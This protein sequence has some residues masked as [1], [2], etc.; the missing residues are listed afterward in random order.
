MTAL[1][2]QEDYDNNERRCQMYESQLHGVGGEPYLKY[3]M[4]DRGLSLETIKH[5]RLG[6]VVNPDPQDHKFQYRICIPHMN[7]R[8]VSVLRFRAAPGQ[9]GPKYL[10]PTGSRIS[11]YNVAQLSEPLDYVMVAEG[12]CLPGSA[13]VFTPQG[14]TRMDALDKGVPVAQYEASGKLTLV[15]PVAYV[16]KH[17]E[18]DLIEYANTRRYYSLTTPGH[19]MPGLTVGG[20][21][22]KFRAD[23]GAP[24]SRHI[25]RVGTLDGDGTGLSEDHLALM[26]AISADASVRSPKGGEPVGR[27]RKA[28]GKHYYVFGFTKV[29]KILRLT[30]ILDRLDIPYSSE[31]IK[32]GCQSICFSSTEEIEWMGRMLPHDLLAK[33]SLDEREFCLREMV[34]WDGN[35]VPNRNQHEYSSKHLA[36]AEWMQTLAHTAGRVSTIMA[37]SNAYGEWYKVSVLHGHRATS[38]Q[39]LRGHERR[40]PFSGVVYCVQ[41]PSGYFLVRQNGCVTITGNCDAMTLVQCGYPAVG[42]PGASTWR[43]HHAY[44]FDGY[45]RVFVLGDGDDAGE[46]FASKVAR[47]VPNPRVIALPD[48]Q[49]V[50]GLY[51]EQGIEAIHKLLGIKN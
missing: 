50:N 13:E 10:Q 4:E 48:N 5:F 14:W 6:A 1:L 21:L 49:D 33:M 32:G 11:V 18:G 43:D 28:A 26:L 51:V 27:R 39:S 30:Q 15:N 7:L 24:A 19:G 9:S 20:Q 29:R 37:R 31:R 42:F 3:L 38:W 16:E 36:N 34:E 40:V 46:E 23:G 35:S 22:D 12:E 44:L 41:V 17:Y 45:Q 25:P 47:H 8:G 2:P